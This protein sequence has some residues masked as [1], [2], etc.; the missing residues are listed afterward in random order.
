MEALRDLTWTG[1][2]ILVKIWLQCS[3]LWICRFDQLLRVHLPSVNNLSWPSG[4]ITTSI[5]SS[6]TNT[7]DLLLR[8][9]QTWRNLSC[10]VTRLV[11]IGFSVVSHLFLFTSDLY[12]LPDVSVPPK[13]TAPVLLSIIF[14]ISRAL[15]HW[16]LSIIVLNPFFGLESKKKRM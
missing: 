12:R 4:P 13:E 1:Q 14:K 5:C 7:S 9:V 3:L 11:C 16:L 10:L 8:F 15:V 2:T 6:S